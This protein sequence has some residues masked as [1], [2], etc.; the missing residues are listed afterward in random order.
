[1]PYSKETVMKTKEEIKATER[2][3]EIRGDVFTLNEFLELIQDGMFIPYDGSGYF[4]DGEKE[5]DRSVWAEDLSLMELKKYPY[6]C[7]YNK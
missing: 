4:H 6:V 7:W 1:V 2:V 3:G 5:T